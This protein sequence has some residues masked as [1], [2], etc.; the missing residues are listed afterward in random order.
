[1]QEAILELELKRIYVSDNPIMQRDMELMQGDWLNAEDTNYQ[2]IIHGKM[3]LFNNDSTSKSYLMEESYIIEWTDSLPQYVLA[4]VPDIRFIIL[5]NDLDILEC[6]ILELND[7]IFRLMS[8]PGVN[9]LLYNK[10]GAKSFKKSKTKPYQKQ[11]N[12]HFFCSHKLKLI[13][14]NS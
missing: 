6:Q 14:S 10:I 5:K 9:E 12:K 13:E 8:I 3:L 7:S 2:I 11:R 4:S 1:M